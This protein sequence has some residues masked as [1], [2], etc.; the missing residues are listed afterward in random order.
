MLTEKQE[1]QIESREV[2]IVDI[3][4]GCQQRR[5]MEIPAMILKQNFLVRSNAENPIQ[6]MNG[7]I[8]KVNDLLNEEAHYFISLG[9]EPPYVS[10][11]EKIH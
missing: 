7:W 2:E 6:S 4:K 9:I 1:K 5:F 11:L 8:Q 10:Q 3:L